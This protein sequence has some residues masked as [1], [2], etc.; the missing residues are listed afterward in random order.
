MFQN[1]LGTFKSNVPTMFQN[2]KMKIPV[3]ILLDVEMPMRLL[4]FES[5]DDIRENIFNQ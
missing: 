2:D 4:L 1:V 3:T 5:P